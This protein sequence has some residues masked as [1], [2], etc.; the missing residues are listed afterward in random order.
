MIYRGISKYHGDYALVSSSNMVIG[1]LFELSL[2]FCFGKYV[3]VKQVEQH[4]R[5]VV[6]LSGEKGS[7]GGQEHGV[8]DVS[9]PERHSFFQFS[10]VCKSS[11]LTV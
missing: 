4:A 3:G 9:H 11:I 5:L 1:C 2:S 10:E 6:V 8:K 7:S